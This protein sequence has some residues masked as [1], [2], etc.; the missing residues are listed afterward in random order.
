M[1]R[2]LHRDVCH[3]PDKRRDKDAQHGP[4][5]GHHDIEAHLPAQIGDAREQLITFGVLPDDENP[6]Y[7]ANKAR[8]HHRQD[9]VPPYIPSPHPT[10][11]S[12]LAQVDM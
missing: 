11:G 12:G 1:P 8:T 5:V 9:G 2:R 10:H 6:K 3:K 7:D 4:D